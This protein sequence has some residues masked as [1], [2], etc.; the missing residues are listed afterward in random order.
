MPIIWLEAAG[1]AR[2]LLSL[3]RQVI[4]KSFDVGRRKQEAFQGTFE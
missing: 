1:F 4:F 2:R 3:S